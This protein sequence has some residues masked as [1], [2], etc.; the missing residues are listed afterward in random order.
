MNF[1]DA[2][3]QHKDVYLFDLS[4]GRVLFHLLDYD[5]YSSI[6]YV[7]KGYPEFKFDLEDR[8]WD[9]CVIDHTFSLHKEQLSAGIIT[10]IAQL[11]IYLSAPHNTDEINRDLLHARD[12]LNDAMEQIIITICE[13]FPSYLPE[14]IEKL[15]WATVIKRLAQAERI[16]NKD[17]EFHDVTSQ[18]QDDSGRIFKELDDLSSNSLDFTKLNQELTEA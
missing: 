13:A 17:F 6:R 12:S 14:S 8:V 5:S 16:L 3:K 15:P 7:M 1:E 9:K 18:Q 10:T 2:I 4:E 11:I